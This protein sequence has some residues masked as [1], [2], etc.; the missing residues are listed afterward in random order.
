M[1]EDSFGASSV[2]DA[3]D[4]DEAIQRHL[5]HYGLLYLEHEPNVTDTPNGIPCRDSPC[6]TLDREEILGRRGR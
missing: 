5:L 1:V 2:H 3:E 6:G 4:K